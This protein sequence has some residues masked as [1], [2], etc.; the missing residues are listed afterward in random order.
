MRRMFK[1]KSVGM[2]STRGRPGGTYNP[3]RRAEKAQAKAERTTRRRI[4]KRNKRAAIR[5]KLANPLV[6]SDG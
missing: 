3:V 4:H 5:E 2:L 6:R 1:G